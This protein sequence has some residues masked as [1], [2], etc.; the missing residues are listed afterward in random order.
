MSY[1]KSILIYVKL[2]HEEILMFNGDRFNEI[3]FVKLS[4]FRHLPFTASKKM[5]FTDPYKVHGGR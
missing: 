4:L 3:S 2:D 5:G 1:E